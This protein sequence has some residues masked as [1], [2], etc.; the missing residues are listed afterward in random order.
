M[1]LVIVIIHNMA[2]KMTQEFLTV[3][4]VQLQREVKELWI[5]IMLLDVI[6]ALICC[7]SKL[8]AC[9]VGQ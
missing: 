3:S 4:C 5:V 2:F 7:A 1:I 9:W 6:Y 8:E